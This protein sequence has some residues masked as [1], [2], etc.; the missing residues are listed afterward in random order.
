MNDHMSGTAALQRSLM[1]IDSKQRAVLTIAA[2][3]RLVQMKRTFSQTD[4][5]RLVT[6]ELLEQLVINGP[7]AERDEVLKKSERHQSFDWSLT[8]GL[9]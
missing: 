8:A 5:S 2:L 1:F 6:F 4:A 9:V 3:T 7:V